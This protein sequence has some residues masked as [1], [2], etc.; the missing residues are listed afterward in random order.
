M[1]LRPS[2]GSGTRWTICGHHLGEQLLHAAVELVTNRADL[3][4]RPSR[5]VPKL[6]V[7]IALARVNGTGVT[8]RGPEKWST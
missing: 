3:L 7:E 8:D 1:A 4:E 5:R 2:F 6:P